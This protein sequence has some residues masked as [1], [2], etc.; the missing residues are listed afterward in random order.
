MDFTVKEQRSCVHTCEMKSL[1][2]EIKIIFNGVEGVGVILRFL[3]MDLF[4]YVEKSYQTIQ[5]EVGLAY[6]I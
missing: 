3:T 5:C 4:I 1:D 2:Y 6:L